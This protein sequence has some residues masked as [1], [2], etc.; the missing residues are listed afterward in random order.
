MTSSCVL[1]PAIESI[2]LYLQ[3]TMRSNNVIVTT[4]HACWKRKKQDRSVAAFSSYWSEGIRTK[5]KYVVYLTNKRITFLW[6]L[7]QINCPSHSMIISNIV[8]WLKKK[9]QSI[10]LNV[11]NYRCSKQLSKYQIRKRPYDA[12]GIVVLRTR[13]VPFL[14]SSPSFYK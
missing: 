12:S 10:N 8:D 7:K 1:Q 3:P 2:K 13:W 14:S 6:L 4:Y 5:L 11:Y 9:Q